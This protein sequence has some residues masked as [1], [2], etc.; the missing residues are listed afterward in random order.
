MKMIR[1]LIPLLLLAA[2]V[3]SFAACGEKP[4]VYPELRAHVEEKVGIGKGLTMTNQNS[5][6]QAFLWIKATKEGED[7]PAGAEPLYLSAIVMAADNRYSHRVNILLEDSETLQWEWRYSDT[8]QGKVVYTANATLKASAYRGTKA[9][10][11]DSF[12]DDYLTETTASTAAE[13][14]DLQASV[15]DMATDLTNGALAALDAY[16][17][18]NLDATIDNLGFTALSEDFRY[19][20]Q[21][22]L[23]V[24]DHLDPAFVTLS[25]EPGTGAVAPETETD[26][27][28]DLGG[29]LSAARWSYALRMTLLGMGMVFAVL[30][31]LWMILVIFRSLA[32]GKEPKA[33]KASKA[34]KEKPAEPAPAP[35]APAPAPAAPAQNDPAV[36]AAITAAIAAMIESDPDLSAQFIGGFRVVSFKRKTGRTSWNQ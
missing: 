4:N 32:G 36:V 24:G 22:S 29:A 14:K 18:I 7:T 10:S 27:A 19:K 2:M 8:Q 15:A 34:P 16:L 20:P 30:A 25:A 12:K 9:I 28:E 23:A 1:K 3:L 6:V 31:I 35:V 33:P 13:N 26:A 5:K 17:Q 11:L 21:K